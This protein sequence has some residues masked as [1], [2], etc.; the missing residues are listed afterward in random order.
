MKKRGW[1]YGGVALI[2]LA[3]TGIFTLSGMN[4]HHEG[5]M[6]G[7]GG[8]DRND[9][10]SLDHLPAGMRH[11]PAADVFQASCSGCHA[12][13]DPRRYSAAEW[14]A[15]VARMR[16]HMVTQGRPVPPPEVLGTVVE[17]LQRHAR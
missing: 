15:V 4:R 3:L 17:F 13:P 8:E 12:P 10:H 7:M 14:P 16:Q 1:F 5:M 6:G 2:L 9:A 11:D